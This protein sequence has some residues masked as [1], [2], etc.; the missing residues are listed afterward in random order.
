MKFSV[1]IPLYNKQNYIRRTLESV[2]AQT[3]TDFEVIVVNDGSK[4]NSLLEA[5]KVKDDRIRIIDKENGGVSSARNRG[6]QEAKNEW[7]CFFDADDIMYP[8]CLEEY[9]KL[10]NLFSDTKVLCGSLDTNIRKYPTQERRYVISNYYRANVYSEMRTGISVTCTD[11]IC[12][13]RS[14]FNLVGMFFP[15]Y[16]HGEDLHLWDRLQQN[17]RFAKSEVAVAYY[18]MGAE[19]RSDIVSVKSS[20]H[21]QPQVFTHKP[22][23]KEPLYKHVVFGSREF[24]R[25]LA[26]KNIS[27]K[28]LRLFHSCGDI[29]MFIAL[30][31]LVRIGVIQSR[32]I[33]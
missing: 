3:Y 32:G 9:H 10:H 29:G 13:H 18:D 28:M 25:V 21:F 33:A 17:F 23:L 31:C 19:N 4:D 5:R 15:Q 2:L 22:S 30:K 6:I 1:I 27:R 20:A 24:Y 26:E 16:T 12:I 11:C 7:I 8:H 14:C